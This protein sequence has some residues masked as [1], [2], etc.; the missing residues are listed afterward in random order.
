MPKS[1]EEI[2]FKSP[3]TTAKLAQNLKHGKK[4]QQR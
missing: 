4:I 3:K 2:G 1:G